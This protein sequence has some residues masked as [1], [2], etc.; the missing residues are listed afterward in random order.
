MNKIGVLSIIRRNLKN[1]FNVAMRLELQSLGLMRS[2]RKIRIVFRSGEVF[3][4]DSYY[5]ARRIIDYS[6]TPSILHNRLCH[7]GCFTMFGNKKV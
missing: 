1:W 2:E 3:V 7:F 4:S 6:V 5:I